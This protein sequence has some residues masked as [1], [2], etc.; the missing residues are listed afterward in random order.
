M[1]LQEG[2]LPLVRANLFFPQG[3]WWENA[4]ERGAVDTMGALLTYGGAGKRS[5]DEFEAEVEKLSASLTSS[6]GGEY[7]QVS[8]S[9]LKAT[10]PEVFHL[11]E[12]VILEPRFEMSRLDL[13]KARALDAI[14]RRKDDGDTMASLSMSALL[15]G[16]N[17]PFGRVLDSSQVSAL[18]QE[19]MRREHA[20]YVIPNKAILTITGDITK[21]E[22]DKLLSAR[23]EKWRGKADF[24]DLP[25]PKDPSSKIVFIEG[26][27]E[28][29]SVLIGQLGI[30]RQGPLQYAIQVFND[31]FGAGGQESELFKKVRS[32]RGLAYDVSGAVSPGKIRG[33][34][35]ISL[36]TKA[37][38]VG[39]AVVASLDVLRLLKETPFSTQGVDERKRG[40]VN[41]FVFAN[42][43]TDATLRRRALFQLLGYPPNYD[44]TYT[45]LIEK[46]TPADVQ[47]VAKSVWTMSGL[48]LVVVGPKDALAS[49]RQVH[50]ALPSPLKEQKIQIASFNERLTLLDD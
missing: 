14:R 5:A 28:Q 7:G 29:A 23:I 16:T 9:S 25:S 27:F 36:Q 49:L 30:A 34:N 43:S 3:S 8:F 21:A 15:Y 50:K 20:R 32:A 22:V 19:L 35:S 24:A 47:E 11:F 1:H 6:F 41:G 40:V 46:V 2:E 38:S 10:L 48:T 12:D 31:I 44:D 39:E 26:P 42:E 4:H 13:T 33:V 37:E 45:Q 17:S 18:S